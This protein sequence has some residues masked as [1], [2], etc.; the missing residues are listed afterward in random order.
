MERVGLYPPWAVGIVLTS[1]ERRGCHGGMNRL[2][3]RELIVW[4]NQDL[5]A[6]LAQALADSAA[7]NTVDLGDFSQYADDGVAD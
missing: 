4:E 2:P 7:G 6:S 1:T 3:R 5:R